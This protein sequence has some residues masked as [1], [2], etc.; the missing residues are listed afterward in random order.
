M[1]QS[2]QIDK[3][4][5]S[6]FN[7]DVAPTLI[8]DGKWEFIVP[9]GHMYGDP[10]WITVDCQGQGVTLSDGGTVA[11]E[12]FSLDHEDVRSHAFKILSSLAKA[13]DLV[14]DMD[15]GLIEANCSMNG[16]G[17]TLLSFIR[18]LLATMTVA[19]HLETVSKAR[20]ALGP[21][22][23]SRIRASCEEL[24][25]L[26]LIHRN[27]FLRGAR[28]SYWPTDFQ[29]KTNTAPIAQS[30]SVLAADLNIK[31]PIQKASRL[32]MIALDTKA[33]RA[34]HNL[35]IVIDS[36]TLHAEQSRVAADLIVEHAE[37]L[38]YSVCDFGD[39]GGREEFLTQMRNELY[40]SGGITFEYSGMVASSTR[41]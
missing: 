18:V 6:L 12:L 40:H 41:R 38:E 10:F 1:G 11:G 39:E 32:S 14:I 35:R 2:E 31:D 27:G 13:H 36:E 23:R 26:H 5:S 15:R 20:S 25:V 33:E 4:I 3:V 24:G 9:F 22:L 37:T 21:R 34:G 7:Y 16:L 28:N 29:W 30:V 17:D 8:D 19:P